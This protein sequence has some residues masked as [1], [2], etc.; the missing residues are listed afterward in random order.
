VGVLALANW[1]RRLISLVWILLP[2]LSYGLYLTLF[3][4]DVLEGM[5]AASPIVY[6]PLAFLIAFL[7]LIVNK[8]LLLI[9]YYVLSWVAVFIGYYFYSKRKQ[10]VRTLPQ[11]T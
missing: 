7:D 4:G 2:F 5:P 9:L 8:W 6:V 1:K 3:D 10:R 11:E